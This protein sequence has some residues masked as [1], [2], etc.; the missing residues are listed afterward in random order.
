[1]TSILS[2]TVVSISAIFCCSFFGG[3]AIVMSSKA[4]FEISKKVLPA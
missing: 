4:F 1:M 3:R 2:S